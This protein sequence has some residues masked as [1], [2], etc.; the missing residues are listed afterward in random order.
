LATREAPGIATQDINH[1]APTPYAGSP[2]SYLDMPTAAPM[3]IVELMPGARNL[4]EYA[5]LRAG[6]RVLI[7]TEHT[8]DPVVLQA[9]A[10]AASYR[11]A[12]VHILSV[13]PFSPGGV[14][15]ENPS[16]IAPAAH[17]EADLVVACTWWGEVHTKQLFFSEVAQKQARFVSLHM[18][19]TA[20]V[21]ATGART[22][23]EVF[24]AILRK[25]QAIMTA[26]SE[27][28]VTTPAG[29]DITFHEITPTPDEGPLEP[30]GWRPFP[31]GGV[32]F[33]PQST[34]GVFVVEDSTVTGVPERPLRVTVEDNI[35]TDIDGGREAE[36]LRTYGPQGYYMRHALVGL[37]PKVRIAG[38]TQF[39][40]EKHAGAFYLGIDGLTDGKPDP[41]NPG[42]AHCDCQFDRPDVWVGDEQIVR[43]GNLLL[44]DDSEIREAAARFGPPEIL[45]DANPQMIL[46]A[47]YAGIAA[48]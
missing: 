32:N 27:V 20:S 13:A 47:R 30:G 8:V 48:S 40:R 5:R 29:T 41:A 1:V 9:L 11:G 16:A 37:N 15:Q 23:P 46:P 34:D 31:Y 38:A 26:G 17:A 44:L 45:L 35:V 19:A 22:P 4:M 33:Y 24:Y 2:F 10:A 6:E 12:D 28:R 18:A 14:D 3:G 25:T 42:Y 21:L 7:L 43:D 39:E 36:Q